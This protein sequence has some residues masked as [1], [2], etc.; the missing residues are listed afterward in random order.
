MIVPWDLAPTI[1]DRRGGIGP[2]PVRRRPARPRGHGDP[3]GRQT[4]AVGVRGPRPALTLR[5]FHRSRHAENRGLSPPESV[6][7][8]LVP[9]RQAIEH[10][11]VELPLGH[12][13][14]HQRDEAGVVR[15]LQ[16]V[17]HLVDDDVFE[18]LARLLGEI[19]VEA[20][21]CARRGCSFPT[22]SSSAARRTA[23][24]SRPCSGSH[25]AISGGTASFSCSRY[26]SSTI[27]CRFRSSVPGRTRSSMRLCF[28]STDGGCVALDDLEQVALAPDVV[29]FPVQVLARR[30]AFLLPQLRLLLLDPAELRDGEDADG[31]E[32]HARRGGDAHTAA[33][34]DGRSGG[35]S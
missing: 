2:K 10:V 29:A 11:P 24:P 12:E 17:D 32:A 1:C 6:V 7:P 27:A 16:Q 23:P 20:D 18:A 21:A 8:A 33:S 13:S 5:A 15:R 4:A 14:I 30:L 26:H 34:A 22:S 28:S 25:F 19:G 35:R 3:T 9:H 31:V